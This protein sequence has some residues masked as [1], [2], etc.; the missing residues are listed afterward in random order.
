LTF[1]SLALLAGVV[2]LY[3][4]DKNRDGAASTVKEAEAAE[5][6]KKSMTQ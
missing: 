4:R 2:I 5:V 6:G 3:L 1:I